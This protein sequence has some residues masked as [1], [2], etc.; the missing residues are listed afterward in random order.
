M[1]PTLLVL[2]ILT[3]LTSA[4]LA[5]PYHFLY[6]YDRM[7][8]GLC[9]Y[10]L[11]LWYCCQHFLFFFKLGY[12]WFTICLN[13][14]SFI[15]N[16]T[17]FKSWPGQKEHNNTSLEFSRNLRPCIQGSALY[18]SLNTFIHATSLIISSSCVHIWFN[19]TKV[20]MLLVC[21]MTFQ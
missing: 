3:I 11:L 15:S 16:M 13:C 4:A 21:L 7:S 9:V 14:Q 19:N 17:L 18:S 8:N 10:H 1:S 5:L 2:L 12:S 20:F 6:L